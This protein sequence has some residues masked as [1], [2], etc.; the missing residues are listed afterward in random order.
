MV[1]GRYESSLRH[2]RRCRCR[3]APYLCRSDLPVQVGAATAATIIVYRSAA[4][5]A[6]TAGTA[7]TS[8]VIKKAISYAIYM[9]PTASCPIDKY[10]SGYI[11][12][13]KLRVRN[14]NFIF[15]FLE[16]RN[17]FF[18]ILFIQKISIN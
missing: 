8:G 6:G 1:R 7:G 14:F 15:A 12:Y 11:I 18:V 2:Y 13:K 5:A 10:G 9:W 16:V 4:A 17:F 3:R